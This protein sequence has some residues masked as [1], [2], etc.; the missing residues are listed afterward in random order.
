LNKSIYFFDFDSTLINAET[1][2][3]IASNK[4]LKDFEIEKIKEITNQAMNGEISFNKALNERLKILKINQ[5]DVFEIKNQIHAKINKS[6]LD[7]ISFFSKNN[8]FII[9]GG[10][11]EIIQPVADIL[12]IPFEKV[13]ANNL[14]FDQQFEHFILDNENPLAHN[15]GK[16][17]VINQLDFKENQI[18]IGDGYT[19][20]EVKLENPKIKFYAY[21][22]VVYRNNIVI[23]ADKVVS[24]LN[25]L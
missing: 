22:E 10:F 14:I 1:L 12:K 18:M 6:I 2:D 9:S 4:N 17:H 13:F 3:L 7:N 8:C 24:N 16:S 19:D 21:T 5:N 25:E 20:L 23:Q 15:K 11:R